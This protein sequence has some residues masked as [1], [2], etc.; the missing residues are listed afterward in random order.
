MFRISEFNPKD[1]TLDRI[2]AI[3][4]KIYAEDKGLSWEKVIQKYKRIRHEFSKKYHLNFKLAS[5]KLVLR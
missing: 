3:Q 2:H 1:K 5:Q 4:K